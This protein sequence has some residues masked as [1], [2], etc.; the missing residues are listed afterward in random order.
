MVGR[1]QRLVNRSP[2][3][4]A[5]EFLGIIHTD[6]GGPYTPTRYGERYFMTLKDD[7]T[8]VVWVF[9]LKIKGQTLDKFKQFTAWI[10]KQS[11]Q[12]IKHVRG[13]GGGE[14]VNTELL[15]FFKE[16]G[17]QWEARAPY[18][19]EQNGRAERQNST[20]MAPTR[21]WLKAKKLPKSLWG[22]VIKTSAYIKN[23]CPGVDEITPYERLNKEK[24]TLSHLRIIGSR[25]WVHIPKEKRTKLDDRSWQGIFVGYDGTNQF[26]IYDPRTGK[27]HIS[28]DIQVDELNTYDSKETKDWDLADVAW[29]EDDDACFQDPDDFEDLKHKNSTPLYPAS[30]SLS[31]LNSQQRL[32]LTKPRNE[33]Y[34]MGETAPEAANDDTNHRDQESEESDP[35]Q[36]SIPAPRRSGRLRNPSKP[37]ADTIRYD[38]SKKSLPK[39]ANDGYLVK[40][41]TTFTSTQTPKFHEHMVRV[42]ALLARGSETAGQDEPAT[43][44]EAMASPHW[45]EW[46]KAMEAEY[47]SLM[48]NE[49]WTL[50]D[51]PTDRK[52]I[53]GRWVFKLIKD[54]NGDILKYKARWVVH[55]YKQKEGL[56]YLDTFATVVK[57]ISY[58]TLIGISAK[59]GL[60]IRHMDVVTAFLYG[61]LDE[62]IYIIQPTLFEVAGGEQKVCLLRKALYGLKQSPRVWYQTLLDFL[63]KIGFK[64][65]ESDHGVFVSEDMFIAIYVDDLFIMGKDTLKLQQLQAELKS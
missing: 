49:T 6:L 57:P 30:N 8:G 18:V 28:R 21:S 61:Y 17:I 52:T 3:S 31:S 33:S 1:Q 51:A 48:D 22:E 60:S 12:K 14:Y 26:R 35:D 39:V 10:E 23:R 40:K 7:A 15:T 63:Q 29:D 32:S 45:D 16:E 24:P 5:P 34:P 59:R 42:L 44:R 53:T 46:R 64:H 25:T 50:T 36:P 62:E 58:K 38:I 13:D 19:P 4:R 56:D 41:V 47:Q 9:L 20:L 27:V 55:G 43:L 54:R 11:G 37:A 65:T 2:R